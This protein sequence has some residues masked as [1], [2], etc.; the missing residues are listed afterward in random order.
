MNK[1]NEVEL[2]ILLKEGARLPEYKTS[3]AA[4]ADLCAFLEKDLV[5]KPF[6]RCAVPTGLFF[7]IPDDYEI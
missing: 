3:G 7:E 2:K 6:E 1:K 4:G 5:L